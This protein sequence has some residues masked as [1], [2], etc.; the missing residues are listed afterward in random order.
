MTDLNPKIIADLEQLLSSLNE[1]LASFLLYLD[2]ERAILEHSEI[3]ALDHSLI[4]KKSLIHAIEQLFAHYQTLFKHTQYA[5]ND[6]NMMNIIKLYPDNAGLKQKYLAFKDLVH[7]CDQKNLTNGIIITRV[8]NIND[9]L[10][11]TL[12]GR[13]QPLTYL[14]T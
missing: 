8:K 6:V 1:Y 14:K 2:K 9:S 11:H 13:P 4:E 7:E 5:L 3:A 10:L 12:L